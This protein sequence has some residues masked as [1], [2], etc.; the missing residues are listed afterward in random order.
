MECIGLGVWAGVKGTQMLFKVFELIARAKPE[1]REKATELEVY[2][3]KGL[4]MLL[5]N[6]LLNPSLRPSNATCLTM[7]NALADCRRDTPSLQEKDNAKAPSRGKSLAEVNEH[8]FVQ[9]MGTC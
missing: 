5:S 6:A 8:C 9:I 4:S 3:S 1:L 7:E 2:R